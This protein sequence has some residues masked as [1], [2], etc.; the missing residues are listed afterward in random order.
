ML[1]EP[2]GV[3]G[4]DRHVAGVDNFGHDR[5]SSALAGISQQAQCLLAEALE[6]V[7]RRAWLEGPASEHGRAGS[8][9]RVRGLEQLLAALHSAWTGHHR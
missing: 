5:Q 7:G 3:G 1:R 2:I 4:D 8:F 9:D 6:V